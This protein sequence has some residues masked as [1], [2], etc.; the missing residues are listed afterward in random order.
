MNTEQESSGLGHILQ[1]A[2]IARGISRERLARE[3]HLPV[4]LLDAIEMDR[5]DKVPPGRERPLA[6]ILA[7]SVGLDLTQY[8]EAWDA[9][10]GVP[11]QEV[12]DPKQDLVEQV[13]MG[14]MTL[15][16]IGL[17]AWLLIPGR[18]LKGSVEFT[19]HVQT[20]SKPSAWKPPVSGQ[21]YPV[22]GDVL[23]E[24][25]INDQGILVS[26]RSM[27]T[28]EVRIKKKEGETLRQTLRISEPWNLRVKGPFMVYLDNAGVVNLEVAG[29]RIQHGASVATPWSGQFSEE[30]RWILPKKNTETMPPTAPETAPE[31][32]DQ[33]D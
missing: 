18:D 29:Q 3:V 22:L 1:E 6:R 30:G 9:V 16:S 31:A 15:G 8:P 12:G 11:D 19:R 4:L 14:V 21:P 7:R 27:D 23:P 25:P 17:L 32:S 13:I 5:W 20:S 26:L 10:P 2:R 28:C 33:R 24:I